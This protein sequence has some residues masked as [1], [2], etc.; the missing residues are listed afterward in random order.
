MARLPNVGGDNNQ[1]GQILNDFL[2][3]EL[4]TDGTLKKAGDIVAA[5]N[6]ANAKYTKPGSGI[7]ESDLDSSVQSKLNAGAPDATSSAKGVV[8]L[9]GDLGGTAASPTVPGLSSKE[10]TA[11]KSAATTLGASDTLYPTQNAVKSYVDTSISGLSANYIANGTSPQTANFNISGNGV[12]GGNLS[13]NGAAPDAFNGAILNIGGSLTSTNNNQAGIG[14]FP[15]LIPGS[16]ST[17]GLFGLSFL[18]VSD[19]NNLTGGFVA[20][21]YGGFY[22]YGT[23][24]VGNAIGGF[25]QVQNDSSGTLTNV[26]S[27]YAANPSN[28]GTITSSVGI[29]IDNQT[30]GASNTNILISTGSVPVGNYSIYNASANNNYFAGK[31]LIGTTSVTSGQLNFGGTGSASGIYFNTDTNLYRS[32]P[33]TL[34]T[35]DQVK[36]IAG[37]VNA[38]WG[39]TLSQGNSGGNTNSG[40][41][42]FANEGD[43]A[44]GAF[45]ISRA[46]AASLV[47]NSGA[48]PGSSSGS[49]IVNISSAGQV[50]IVTN[51]STGG[52]IIGSDT[53]LYRSATDTLRTDDN[54]IVAAAGTV[55]NSVATIDATQTLT[56]KRI[57]KRVNSTASSAT[58]TPNAGTDDMYVLT[59]LAAAATFGAPTGTPTDG[60]PLV[61]RIK[62]N[63]TARALTWNAIYRAVGTALPT[64]TVISKTLYLGFKY[65]A[66]DTKWD[67]L[68]VSQE[69]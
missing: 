59:A 24:T 30:A 66:A 64:T 10:N 20:G 17:A 2:S 26:T 43:A 15:E 48:T 63:G 51:G 4:N 33:D 12:L 28:T 56:N 42:F 3:V 57:T 61:I 34:T 38:A 60:Q 23:G 65:N 5:Q 1:W 67:C 49:N 29:R 44:A 54:L 19:S 69:A 32:A 27:V 7:P 35:D 68:A 22:Y 6:T 8:Q 58:P 39:L 16:A 13:V 53:N 31:L 55:A 11:N 40:R 62:D 45:A 9:T 47:I 52:L 37:T 18:P 46:G 14:V 21:L 36:V 50:Q 25:F 41:L